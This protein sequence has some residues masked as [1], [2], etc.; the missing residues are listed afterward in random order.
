MLE[1]DGIMNSFHGATQIFL[2]SA[3]ELIRYIDQSAKH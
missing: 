2:R 1:A 3:Q